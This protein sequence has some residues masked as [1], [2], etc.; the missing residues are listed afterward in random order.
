MSCSRRAGCSAR[1]DCRSAGSLM[2]AWVWRGCRRIVV[3]FKSE[4]EILPLK[5]APDEPAKAR[6]LRRGL[7]QQSELRGRLLKHAVTENEVG[8]ADD[9]LGEIARFR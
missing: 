9:A 3:W 4:D 1:E 7:G 8:Q 2:R 5:V 6:A